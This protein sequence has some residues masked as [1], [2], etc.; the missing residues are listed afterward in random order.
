MPNSVKAITPL[1]GQIHDRKRGASGQGEYAQLHLFH[2]RPQSGALYEPVSQRLLPLDDAMAA[3][4][5]RTSLADREPARGHGRRHRDPARAHPRI[6]FHLAL[7]G[8]RR[9]PGERKR[10]PPGGDAARRQKHRRTAGGPQRDIPPSAPERHR[11]GTVR[12]DLRLRG[13]G[14]ARSAEQPLRGRNDFASIGTQSA[15]AVTKTR[16]WRRRRPEAKGPP[17]EQHRA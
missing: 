7:P 9:I 12:R 8:V 14:R 15:G 17:K 4:S 2:N 1:V 10:E 16:N 13:A 3:R 6:S 11:R 5:G